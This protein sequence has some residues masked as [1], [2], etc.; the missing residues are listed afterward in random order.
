MKKIAGVVPAGI[1]DQHVAILGKTRSGKS[2]VMRQCVESL[3]EAGKPVCIVD[4]KGDWWGIKLA[5]DGKGPGYPVVIFGGEHADVP[6]NEH[7]GAHV[8]EL[9]ATGNRPCLIDLGGWTVGARTTFWIDFASTLF[10][11]TKGTRYL[12][13]D[14][15][16]NFCPKGKVMDP[17]AGKMLH[18][19]NRLASE[20]LGKG[21]NMLF[22]SQRPQK[23]HNDSLTSA[24]TLIAMRVLHP[25]DREAI[26]DWIKGCGDGGG[27][28]VLNSLGQM[29]RGEGWVWSPEIGFGPTRVKF[30]M[31]STYDS[32]RPQTVEDTKRLKGW[33]EVDLDEVRAKL[34]KVVE[35]AKANDPKELKRLLASTQAELAKAQRDAAKLQQASPGTATTK[36][37]PALTDADRALIE[38]LVT[39]IGNSRHQLLERIGQGLQSQVDYIN[40]FVGKFL[41]D[42]EDRLEQKGVKKLLDKL[43]GLAVAPQALRHSGPQP[44]GSR[45]P[46]RSVA[47]V[48]NNRTPTS[49]SSASNARRTPPSGDGHGH[50]PPGEHAVLAAAL[51]YPEGLE[52]NRLSIL[53]GY[54]RSSRDAYIVRL[55]SKGLVEVRAQSIYPTADGRAAMP[56]FQPLPTGAALVEYWRQRLPEGE[57]RVLD[58]LLGDQH[59]QTARETID[60]VTGYKRSS[61][62][63]Y[64]VRLKARGLVEFLGRGTVRASADLMEGR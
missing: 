29:E 36:V 9:F 25:S 49:T 47:Q 14:E 3:L 42:H 11:L 41:A 17:A 63:A 54:K 12:A 4:P 8:A 56:D 19:S 1:L 34:G 16:H 55:A 52:R 26:A 20:G 27:A 23:V 10:K 51:T 32:F 6:I 40:G 61:R 64:L 2:S 7:A 33:A 53:T 59:G 35:E 45:L 50:L 57:R 39:A 38:K 30:P 44:T 5:A 18:W 60:D 24:E 21:L 43:N 62:D 28:E 48:S 58:V 13:I 15:F 46:V 22:A 31:F 37:Q